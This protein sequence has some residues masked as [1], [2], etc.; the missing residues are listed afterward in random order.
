MR[1]SRSRPIG[2]SIRPVRDRGEPLHEREVAR[3][4][5][6]GG[7][8]TSCSR[9]CASSERATTSSPDVSRSRRCTIPGR[10]SSPPAASSASRPWTSVPV[11]WPAPGWTTTPAGLS[12]TSR[13]SSSQATRRSISSAAGGAGS[14]GSS[15]TT[16]SPPS[17]RWLFARRS[18]ST[19]TA[20]C[21]D[22]PLGERPRADLGTHGE[23]TIEALGLRGAKAESGQRHAAGASRGRRRRAPRTGS[24]RPTTM[25]TSARLNAGQKRRSRKSVTWPSRTRSSRLATLPPSTKPSATGSTGMAGAR[26]GEE[27]EHPEHRERGQ[28]DHDRRRA[29]EETERDPGVVHVVDREGAGDLDLLA[30]RE[31]PR[32]D[33]LRQL[34]GGDRGDARSSPSP[35]HCCLPAPSLPLAGEDRPQ[36]VRRR[37]DPDVDRAEL[38]APSGLGHLC[39]FRAS[40]M[41]S[42]VH[43]TAS[44]RSA[45]ISL[46]QADAGAVRRRPRSARAPRRPAAAGRVRPPRAP[47]RAPARTSRSRCRRGGCRSSTTSARRS[48]RSATSRR[49][50]GS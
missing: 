40:S 5:P 48:P 50:R 29:R 47:R 11:S 24:R 8:S 9:S 16:S 4:R 15:T 30:Q 35:S 38:L 49:C 18:P 19:S 39:R 7:G 28:R 20:P 14:G 31:R 27:D 12:T 6:R 42:V 33:L 3:A 45:G 34:V 21:G 46:P 25:K 44:S 36:R 17:S 32:D 26:A 1:S 43:G 22:Q 41:Q 2:A 23:R 13:C 10:S 37:A